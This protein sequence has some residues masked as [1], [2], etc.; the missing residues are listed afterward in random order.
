[1][2]GKTI[3]P[4]PKR[5]RA[6]PFQ[7]SM[8]PP[9]GSLSVAF[10]AAFILILQIW[11]SAKWAGLKGWR[12]AAVISCATLL[13]AVG[14]FL[15]YNTPAGRINRFG[16][17]LEWT[18][19]LFGVHALYGF[20]FSHLEIPSGK[21]HRIAGVFHGL[22]LIMLWGTPLLVSRRFT[23]HHFLLCEA[24]FVE[25]TLGPLGPAFMIYAFVAAINAVRL[26]IS[27]VKEGKTDSFAP[28]WGVLIWTLLGAHDGAVAL[29]APSVQYLME[30]GLLGFSFAIFYTMLNDYTRLSHALERANVA[31]R[32]EAET[33]RQ[34]EEKLKKHSDHLEELVGERTRELEQAQDALIRREKLAVLGQLAGGVGHELRNPLGA[35]KNAVYYLNMALD[36][37]EQE[38]REALDILNHEVD[39]SEK[40]IHSLFDVADPKRPKFRS[41]VSLNETIRADLAR[42]DIPRSIEV[43]V[44]MDEELPHATCDPEQME[45]VVGNLLRNAVQAMRKGGRL[46]IWS[47]RLKDG[48]VEIGVSDT[49]EGIPE[50]NLDRIFEPL[51]TNKAK[52]IGLGLALCRTYVEA[53]GGTLDVESREG[54]GATFTV[55]IPLN[56]AGR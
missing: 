11:F 4:C 37:P 22:I 42:L 15:E 30:Y 38:T 48:R 6:M 41:K 34:A 8:I 19:I 54:E 20:V 17:L 56:Q 44:E 14:I 40:I 24:P 47:R 36:E 27:S 5:G 32:A 46:K 29:G 35:I 10:V 16:G 51:F 52:G 7:I 18:A 12:W 26:W 28:A 45:R 53:H 25:A 1:M 55:C 31:L 13:Y 50:E 9:A 49:G 23:E 33:R 3:L 2:I 43:T 21:Y 39:R